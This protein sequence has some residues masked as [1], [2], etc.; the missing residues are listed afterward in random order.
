LLDLPKNFPHTK[1]DFQPDDQNLF[2]LG[3]K[4]DKYVNN[5]KNRLLFHLIFTNVPPYLHT[6]HSQFLH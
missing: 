3:I 5:A 4:L 2:H 6:E 1:T